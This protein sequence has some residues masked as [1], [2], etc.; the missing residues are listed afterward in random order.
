M[1]ESTL[2]PEVLEY[3]DRGG[4]V[5]RL[6]ASATGRLE[7]LRTQDIL[8]RLIGPEPASVLDVGGGTGIHSGW[9]AADGHAV[10][11]IDP[12]AS[13]VAIAA[14][15]PGVDA[16]IGDARDLPVAEA[17]FDVVLLMGP[18]YHL[19]TT[20]ERVAALAEARR[21]VRPGGLVAA[22]VIGRFAP[23]LDALRW[24]LFQREG[25]TGLLDHVAATGELRPRENGLRD[26]FTTAYTHRPE[27]VAEEFAA[28]GMA[29]EVYAVEGA[30]WLPDTLA[31][32]LDDDSS[33]VRLMSGLR[34]F[35]REASLLGASSHL[36]GAA[37]VA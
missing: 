32:L 33:R 2:A 22:A 24:D 28:A 35:E 7:F 4:E 20:A 36:L 6:T 12:V 37:R 34:D 10:T 29:A 3:Y 26:V 13:Q 19:Q 25:A 9:L 23:W 31:A 11:L 14:K 18:L 27:Q 16:R 8:R 30:A 5:T 21:A 15:L 1:N 17:S